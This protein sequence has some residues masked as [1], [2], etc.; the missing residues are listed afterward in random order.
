MADPKRSKI[1]DENRE[2]SARLKALWDAS[3]NRRNQTA[4]GE[5]Y[6]LGSQGNVGHYLNGRS[7][8]NAK[9]AAA[10]A[11]E[12]QCAVAEFSP[13]IA[14]EIARLS[15]SPDGLA[16]R[17]LSPMPPPGMPAIH[18]PI[19]ANAGSMG[20][21]TEVEHDDVMVG[22]IALSPDWVAKR[23]HPSSTEA[24]RFIHAYGDSM[25]PTFEDGDILLVDTG[26]IDTSGAD[27]VYVLASDRRVFIKRVTE[28]FDGVQEVTSDNPTVRTVQELDGRSPIRVLGRVVW[29]WNGRKM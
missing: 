11:E 3:N 2:E 7:A 28:R 9:A 6:G 27:G 23:I 13:R 4:F 19:L 21:G 1:T 5:H 25:R 24:L 15:A 22:A 12:L 26:R 8:L 16:V 14:T 10:F 18:V 17:D 29:V 20:A